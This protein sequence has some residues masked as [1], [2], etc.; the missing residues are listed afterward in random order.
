M[1]TLNLSNI[2]LNQS[3]ENKLEVIELVGQKM[4]EAGYTTEAYTVGLKMREAISSTFLGN[5]IAVPH[6]TPNTRDAV[7]K[8]GVVIL[9]FPRGV[10]WGDGEKVFM[11]V[12]IAACSNEH[13]QIL[14]GLTRMLGNDELCSTLAKTE[15]PQD[16][17]DAINSPPR[18]PELISEER[19]RRRVDSNSPFALKA[20]ASRGSVWPAPEKEVLSRA[21]TIFNPNGMHARP[22]KVFV[23]TI[24]P[25]EC[26]IDVRNPDKSGAFINGKSL[27]KLLSLGITRGTTIEVKASG[28]D[29]Q[30]AMD[31]LE[32]AINEGL[33]E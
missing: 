1:L 23:S 3:A 22:G 7:I 13:L 15:N 4:V 28:P 8:T 12:G 29:A 32:Q 10:D 11:A 31:A 6:G 27:M 30:E 14:R 26:R 19:V 2:F 5:G 25:F 18:V 21:F 17:I 24:K 20:T 16:V 33:A 9:Q